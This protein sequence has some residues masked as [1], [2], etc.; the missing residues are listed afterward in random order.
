[1]KPIKQYLSASTE[2]YQGYVDP[3]FQDLAVQFSRFQDA[4]SSTKVSSSFSRSFTAIPGQS[5]QLD[6]H[7]IHGVVP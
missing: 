2:N 3:R 4:R 7:P 5:S 6:K 1:M